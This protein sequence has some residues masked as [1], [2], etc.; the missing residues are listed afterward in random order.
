MKTQ[1]ETPIKM[2]A[3]IK[4]VI[5]NTI[6]NTTAHGFSRIITSQLWLLK[7]AWLCCM[8]AA[9]TGCTFLLHKSVV[10]F[11]NYEVVTTIRKYDNN[12]A[13]F[14]VVAIC[15]INLVTNTRIQALVN[16]L[17]NEPAMSKAS[18]TSYE[19]MPVFVSAILS[20]EYF[21]DT[22]RASMGLSFDEFVIECSFNQAKCSPLHWVWFFDGLF[23][24][25]FRFN[26][27]VNKNGGSIPL[28]KSTKAG[29][30]NGLS[31]M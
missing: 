6:Q 12:P 23:G 20:S 17:I 15:N 9:I 14:P 1:V 29:Y 28:L 8:L 13:T 5:V 31:L 10:D 19:S 11:L 2:S 21:N 27:G 7:L 24:N 26:S 4:S 25:C 16:T 22:F 18:V 30:W 3:E